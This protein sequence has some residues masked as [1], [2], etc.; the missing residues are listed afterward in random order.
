[1]ADTNL[2]MHNAPDYALFAAEVAATS[3]H[4]VIPPETDDRLFLR[5]VVDQ[6]GNVEYERASH[7]E[8]A[9]YVRSRVNQT[10]LALYASGFRRMEKLRTVAKMATSTRG[11]AITAGVTVTPQG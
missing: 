9:E 7:H 5:K 1:M 4:G 11:R 2:A 10:E 8:A 6:D 3:M